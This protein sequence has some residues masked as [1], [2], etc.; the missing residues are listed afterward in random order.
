MKHFLSLSLMLL[1]SAIL[2]A[3]PFPV[4]TLF[5]RMERQALLYPMEKVHL[6]TDR[7]TYVAG[8]T[9][10]V[11][12]Y[13]V[14][15]ITHLPSRR[16]R[17]VY[18][19]LQN[20]FGEVVSRVCL[21]PDSSG[22]IHGNLVLPD[23]LAKGDYTLTAYTRYM[24]NQDE[25]YFFRKRIHVS[26]VM[27]N[28]IR[29]ETKVRGSHLDIL[30]RNPVTGEVKDI[31]HCVTRVSSGEINVQR[32]D[33]GYSVKFHDSGDKVLLV[34]AGNYQEF[35]SLDTK[36]D[37][38]VSFLPEGGHL[39]SGTMNRVAF[40]SLNSQ[41]QGESVRGTVRDDRDSVLLR[42]ESLHRGMGTFPFI[43]SS[44]KE[45]R[46][47]CENSSG[48]I[49][50]F[51]LP[52][53]TSDYGLQVNEAR[54][55]YFAKVLRSPDTSGLSPAYLL[56]HQQGWP[57][58]VHRYVPD[59][60][61]YTFDSG[62]L[63]SG[64]ASFLLV[65]STGQVLNERMVFVHSALPAVAR[66]VPD[67]TDYGRRE[68]VVLTLDVTGASGHSW[69]GDASLSVV[70]NH[71]LVPD[72]LSSILSTL[73]LESDLRGSIECPAWYFRGGNDSFRRQALDV[74]MMT[75]GWRR[76]RLEDAFSGIYSSPVLQPESGMSL[77]G[78]V[79][80]RV[81][82]KPVPNSRIQLMIPALGITEEGVTGPDG[83]FRFDNFE[84]PDSTVYWVNAYSDK[85]KD[86]VVLDLDS[87]VPPA[88]V[89][90]LP[91][92][93][94]NA[95]AGISPKGLSEYLSKS[96]VR[97]TRENGIRHIFLDEVIIT[98]SK[99][100]PKTEY[101]TII[102]AKSIKEDKINQSGVNELLP[103]LRQQYAAINWIEKNG[104]IMLTIRG[105]P[106]TVIFDGSYCRAYDVGSHNILQYAYLR[107]VA[108]IDIIN[109]PFSLSYD[110]LA[111]GGIV[112]ITTKTGLGTGGAKWHP[113]NLKRIMPLGFQPPVEFYVPRYELT[114]DKEKQDPDLRT[115]IHWQ[116][117]LEV[118]NGKA[119]VEFYTADGPVDY[120][121][122]IEGVGEDGSLLRMEERIK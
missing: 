45:Y 28:A 80:R 43:P 86:N 35:V 5:S 17:Y 54:G 96:D 119:T 7:G 75:Q 59:T 117:H 40:K 14:D 90:V 76:Y 49:K 42:F 122:V 26:S 92:M 15:G 91:P 22:S 16:S 72:S 107:D 44:G 118:K 85:G 104:F 87:V 6:H 46:V 4:D 99:Y 69:T 88:F 48:R 21:R 25:D 55:K 65:S 93:L 39:V 95:G 103:F 18:V 79:S 37:F 34:Q 61:V 78:K 111:G 1:C 47:I 97:M 83:R 56:V 98:A 115:T 41:G 109:H 67:R 12:A 102:G 89:K 8:E 52:S 31:R 10:W 70:D 106:A 63:S 60:D 13:V 77:E 114:A 71:D 51:T 105:E 27:N 57:V 29:L 33:S 84:Y 113:T 120:S 66:L 23:D 116:P 62:K 68:K 64:T 74:L 11:K 94:D 82:R 58:E 100:V 110:P 24:Q 3:Q 73:L 32:K 36:P 53:S 112:A 108:Q 9:V 30:F 101:E 50:E 81:S 19:A 20:P 2:S 121:V 38:D